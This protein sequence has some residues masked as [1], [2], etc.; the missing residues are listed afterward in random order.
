MKRTL[1]EA[2]THLKGIVQGLPRSNNGRAPVHHKEI[3][4][5]LIGRYARNWPNS[6]T[7]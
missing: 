5:T 1:N 3:T 2:M 4:P 7:I 6:N